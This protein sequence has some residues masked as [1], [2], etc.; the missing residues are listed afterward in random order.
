MA[1]IVMACVVMTYIVMAYVVVVLCRSGST[2]AYI[3]S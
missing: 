1:Y 3:L 2:S